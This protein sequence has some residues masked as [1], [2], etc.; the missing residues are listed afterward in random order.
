ML[1]I[2]LRDTN[3]N[4]DKTKAGSTHNDDKVGGCRNDEMVKRKEKRRREKITDGIGLDFKYLSS[5]ESYPE[6]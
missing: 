4:A 3:S 5:L 6:V 1:R 2:Q